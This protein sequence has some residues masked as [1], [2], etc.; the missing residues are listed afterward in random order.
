LFIGQEFSEERIVRTFLFTGTCG[1]SYLFIL[2][3]AIVTTFDVSE[4][5]PD[6]DPLGLSSHLNQR[7][8]A[9]TQLSCNS[10]PVLADLSSSCL[11]FRVLDPAPLNSRAKERTDNRKGN[12]L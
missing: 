10:D 2:K 1:S 8:Q 11:S 5:L 4:W 7:Q 3:F 12:C 9:I 6:I